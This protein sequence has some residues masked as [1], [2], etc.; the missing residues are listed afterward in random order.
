MITI[1]LSK[2][3]QNVSAGVQSAFCTEILHIMLA[4]CT[5]LLLPSYD[6]QNYAD[7]RT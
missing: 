3:F 6:A 2:C 1:H 7:V 5:M 4:L